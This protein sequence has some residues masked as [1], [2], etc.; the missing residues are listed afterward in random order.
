MVT[1][2]AVG[3]G[4]AAAAAASDDE[5]DGFSLD[6]FTIDSP[7]AAAEP[8]AQPHCDLDDAFDLALDDL[9]LGEDKPAAPATQQNDDLSFGSFDLDDDLS[10][11]GSPAEAPSAKAEDDFAFDLDLPEES[12]AKVEAPSLAD[13]LG[14]FSL[15]LDKDLEKDTHATLASAEDDFL[16]GLDDDTASLSGVSPE[17][18]SLD[19]DSKAP[20]ADDLPDDFDLSLADDEPVPAKAADSFAAQLDEVSAELD[21]LSSQNDE[22]Q[23]PVA[24]PLAEDSFL[25]SDLAC[26][27]RGPMT[28]TIS[29]SSPAPMKRPPSSTWRVPTSTW[30]TPKAPA[31]SSMKCSP[32]VTTTSSRKRV[33]CS[34]VSPEPEG[35]R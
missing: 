32:R 9:D 3:G 16:L 23:A 2:A 29:T 5:L 14:D 24:E 10:L 20:Q 19:I 4:L 15:D 11:G 22:A 34:G 21:R 35:S 8:A 31:T 33:N 30:V 1:L 18:F 25:A 26:R 17:E 13:D 12:A 6:D 28:K 7:A 27:A